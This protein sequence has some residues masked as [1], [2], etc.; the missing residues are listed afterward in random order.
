MLF[1]LPRSGQMADMSGS[2]PYDTLDTGWYTCEFESNLFRIS[3]NG[4]SPLCGLAI[5]P[6][7]PSLFLPL[8]CLQSIK[9]IV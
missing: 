7:S 4:F 6:L 1:L 9:E 8:L 3:G 2:L 5:H